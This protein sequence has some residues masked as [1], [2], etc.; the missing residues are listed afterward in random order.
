VFVLGLLSRAASLVVKE[1][2]SQVTR[3]VGT[4]V[5]NTLARKIDPKHNVAPEPV[6]TED[7]P[8]ESKGQT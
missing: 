2:L 8:D 1:L 7:T 6:D 3:E 5:G 4:A